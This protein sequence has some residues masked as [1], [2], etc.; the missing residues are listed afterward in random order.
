MKKFLLLSLIFINSN[1]LVAQSFQGPVKGS[2]SSGVIVSTNNFL[3]TS[4]ISIPK[5]KKIRNEIEYEG[6]AVYDNS[7]TPISSS[8]VKNLDDK[9]LNKIGASD[10][11]QTILIKNF[12]GIGMTNSIPPDPYIAAGP[13][14]IMATVNSKFAIWD[15]EGNLIKS[16]NADD[17]Y[18]TSLPNVS[19]FDP[20]ILYDHFDKRW[21]MVWLDQDDNTQRGNFLV[22]VSDDSDPNGVWYNWVLPSNKN[23]NSVS[24]NWGD[25]EGVGF[26][27]EAIFITSNQFSFSGSFQYA[28]IRIIPKSQLFANTAGELS[29]LD[30]WDIRYPS[31]NQSQKIF[32]IRP[33][34]S[35]SDS[36][37]YYLLHAPNG[38][39]NFMTVVKISNAIDSASLS[40]STK[41]I[42]ISPYNIAPNAD[43]LGGGS[44]LI[45]GSGSA[46]RNEP[47]FRDGFLWTVHSI[48]NPNSSL[49][50]CLDYVKINIRKGQ[51][52]ENF[53]FGDNNH[54]YYYA[55]L[56][57]DKDQNV[58]LT[59]SR[60]GKDE[61]SG[62]FYTTRLSNDPA[63]FS[64]SR[65]LQP[66]KGNYVVTF[67]GDRNRWG[68]YS[69]MWL[70]PEN[71]QNIWMFSE[72]A[73]AA[74]SWGTWVGEIRMQPF[75]GVYAFTNKSELDFGDIE[76]NHDSDT[77]D[78]IL[79]NYGKEDLII[80]TIDQSVGDF[81]LINNINFPLTLTSYDSIT[82][83][84]QFAPK[85]AGVFNQMFS[86]SSN[87]PNLNGITVKA[88]A[89]EINSAELNTLYASSGILNDGKFAK[90]DISTGQGEIIGKSTYGGITNIAIN[91]K[92]KI[93]YAISSSS[94]STDLIRVNSTQGDAYFLHQLDLPDLLSIAF[95]TSGTL[96]AVQKGGK[97]YTI[98]IS[99]GSYN[100]I[101]DTKV[102]IAG[103]AFN[104]INNELWGSAYII[105]GANKDKIFKIN[106]STGDT[107]NV[108]FTGLNVSTN[109]LTFDNTGKLYGITGAS[110]QI[111]NLITIDTSTA[112]GIIIGSIGFKDITGLDYSNNSIA[113]ITKLSNLIP[114]DYSL[115]QNYPNPFNPTTTIEFG[116]PKEANVK[117][118]IYD[119][120][121]EVVNE[122]V[123]DYK[124]AGVYKVNWNSNDN[125]GRILSSGV[126]FYELKVSGS[127]GRELSLIKKMILL[128]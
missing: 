58:A 56:A 53:R 31:P 61:F 82:I 102:N 37:D 60:S 94:V 80:S 93:I 77:L 84:I 66:G 87:D 40:F 41:N 32:N 14:Y 11:A 79:S 75:D 21:V 52:V 112:H 4:P 101:V 45:E 109:D 29:W 25:Y 33:S 125:N 92:S 47:T 19:S 24:S 127:S 9:V 118:I 1:F 59:Y 88:N 91:P 6:P 34:I 115:N 57:V 7:I 50:S 38:G 42:S 96:Y 128:K 13:K 51:A 106:L 2:V 23:G 98:N 89:F 16:I 22:S 8:L 18:S 86:V 116:I 71:E 15:K 26:N 44:P 39:G 73:S 30:V 111:G 35:Y 5:I 117:L 10:S 12:S 119:L 104:P 64:G 113:S 105:I 103:M 74:N 124:Q 83:K 100:L 54:W 43:Q 36:S 70:D 46:L 28:K 95:D 126:Y 85:S 68:D 81:H 65:I 20:K 110:S 78:I 97:I 62:S 17:W 76:A 122:L 48:Q 90:I 27:K 63:G 121:G 49:Y 123:N 3:K 114:E 69:G 72:N 67:S 107:A 108:G 120:L 99:D 55:A